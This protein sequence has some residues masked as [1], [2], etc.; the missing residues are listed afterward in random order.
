M[1]S[2]V[3]FILSIDGNVE[4][5]W[6]RWL[7]VYHLKAFKEALGTVCSQ[8]EWT[9]CDARSTW[10]SWQTAALRPPATT[11]CSR[12]HGPPVLLSVTHFSVQF[13]VLKCDHL[14]GKPGNIS[15]FDSSWQPWVA[16][17]KILHTVSVFKHTWSWQFLAAVCVVLIWLSTVQTAWH[18]LSWFSGK[19]LK[20]LS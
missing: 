11:D 19:S 4:W 9:A 17:Q 15:D 1:D 16:P 5:T 18:L 6:S 3:G 20:L 10:L 12:G 8:W 7:C 14:S 2:A 13:L